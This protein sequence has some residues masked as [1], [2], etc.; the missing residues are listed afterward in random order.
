MAKDT[1]ILIIAYKDYV[2]YCDR[3]EREKK[4]K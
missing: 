3:N 2:E 4:K 1:V